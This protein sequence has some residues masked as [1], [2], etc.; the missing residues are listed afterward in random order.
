MPTTD[1]REQERILAP[2]FRRGD[3]HMLGMLLLHM[4]AGVC[5]ATFY[6]TWLET[7]TIGGLAV[8]T[9]VVAMTLQP[10]AFVTRC[11]AGVSLQAF[12]AL[13]IYQLHGLAEMHFFFFTAFAAMIA[14]QDWRCMWPGAALIIA[15]HVL[16]AMM[17][18]QGINVYFFEGDYIGLTKLGFHFGIAIFHVLLCN[19]WATLLRRQT[20]IDDR[21]QRDLRTAQ[22][23]AERTSAA[24]T[25]FL[26]NM[27]HEL[28]TPM[29]GVLGMAELMLQQDLSTEQRENLEVVRNS[30]KA[31]VDIVN[32]A[33]DLTRV[34]AGRLELS[35]APFDLRR[36]AE[37]VVELLAPRADQHGVELVTRWA[38]SGA[39]MLVGDQGRLRQLLINLT[40][41]AIKFAAGGC[42][43]LDISVA[44]AAPGEKAAV[45]IRVEDD[46]K[47]IAADVLPRLF[48]R[49]EQ[50]SAATFGTHG[51]SGLGLAICRELA[52]LMH[53]N[54]TVHSVL[55][56]GT[57]F[58]FQLMLPIAAPAVPPPRVDLRALLIGSREL[59][60]AVMAEQLEAMGAEV[61]VT[62][63]AAS[64]RELVRAA[65]NRGKPFQLLF[66]DPEALSD[67][68]GID[69]DLRIILL[70][71]DHHETPG[72]RIVWLSRHREL[73]RMVESLGKTTAR[74]TSGRTPR[75]E[76]PKLGLRVLLVEDDAVCAR[77][78]SRMLEILGCKVTP[79]ENGEVALQH[80]R[81]SGFD[82]ILMDC[83]MPIMDG[84]RATEEIRSLEQ[85]GMRIPILALSANSLPEDRARCLRSGADLFLTKPVNLAD[86]CA[87]LASVTPM[88]RQVFADQ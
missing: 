60:M 23:E 51:G 36:L 52:H 79:A 29:A 58:V 15:Q 45:V 43:L 61:A 86:L 27:S 1:R 11:V 6:D 28:R 31:I 56:A 14:Y 68:E 10:G 44:N 7:W 85:P 77:V 48:Q 32:D 4:A 83:R 72:E 20:L 21:I 59:T 50:G 8:G 38:P 57:T 54:I 35:D 76:L 25:E 40:G 88:T 3:R 12:V 69:N 24:K 42:V 47:G 64:A 55:D 80:F 66:T 22:A 63:D 81:A 74:A 78:A 18:N 9:F 33:L 82:A 73:Q 87:A 46:G 5:F 75:A 41:N 49:F 37:E 17:H 53:G 70:G 65:A 2:I 84:Y 26:G 62:R 67:L 19:L 13:H 39:P 71:R 30:A 34:E 16:F